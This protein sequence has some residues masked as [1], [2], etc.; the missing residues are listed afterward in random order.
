MNP[1]TKIPC[2]VGLLAYNSE[3]HLARAL[4]SVKEFEEIIVADGGSTDSTRAI[5][6]SYG[7]RVIDQS[8]PGHPIID[9]AKERN[10]TL[11]AASCPWFF[12]LDSDEIVS[13]ELRDAIA[14]I[15]D[16]DVPYDGY[17]VRYLKT[18]PNGLRQYR[19]F[20][21]YYQLRLFKTSVG[22]TFVRAVHER[23]ELPASARIG[24][25][26]APWYVPLEAEELSLRNM[27]PKVWERTGMEMRAWT[28]G[29]IG[30]VLSRV[31]GI[32]FSR[33]G[34][35]LIKMV[36]VKLRWGG[37]AIPARYELIRIW[38]SLLL[39]VHGLRRMWAWVFGRV[40]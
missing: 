24:V 4:E 20:K 38:Y 19:T 5:A 29:G 22:A 6:E 7:A 40:Y 35:S 8:H 10:R 23:P 14:A 9:F 25:L 37:Q 17:R 26:E 32:P 30:D 3:A 1:S 12:Y 16:S 34:K 31:I 21:E 18:T 33:I 28:P 15:A 2:T 27:F 11:E 36:M 39:T 13:R